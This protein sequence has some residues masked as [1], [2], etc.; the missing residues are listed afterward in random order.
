[1]LQQ[2]LKAFASS[3]V[4]AYLAEFEKEFKLPAAPELQKEIDKSVALFLVLSPAVLSSQYTEN[5]VTWELG[6]ASRAKKEIWVF[7][8]PAQPVVFPIPHVTNYVPFDSSSRPDFQLLQQIIDSYREIRDYAVWG[9]ALGALLGAIVKGKE[10]AFMG[11]LFGF[12]TGPAIKKII[13]PALYGID[14]TCPY[15]NCQASYT[16]RGFVDTFPCPVCRQRITFSQV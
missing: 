5:W 6:V 12:V 4:K 11:G 9:M 8:D 1:M 13:S 14:I 10:G 15:P 16:L 3:P 7:E 2:F